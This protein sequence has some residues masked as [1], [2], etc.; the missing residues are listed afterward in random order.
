MSELIDKPVL[1]LGF[2]EAGLGEVEGSG[3]GERVEEFRLLRALLL[4]RAGLTGEVIGWL[5]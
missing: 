5:S 4:G 2:R 1:F 3:V